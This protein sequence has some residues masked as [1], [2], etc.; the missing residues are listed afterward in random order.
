MRACVD[1]SYTDITEVYLQELRNGNKVNVQSLA[2]KFPQFAD[3]ILHELPL[4]AAL[5]T[6]LSDREAPLPSIP[7]YQLL[8]EI[9]RGN[10]GIVF[11]ARHTSGQLAAVKLVR[12]DR[13][14]ASIARLDREIESLSRL[15]HPNIVN[16]ESSGICDDYVY[17]AT[18]L[19]EG[20]T[21]AEILE[22]KPSLQARY[23]ASMLQ[24]DWNL[25]ATWG[26]Q[27]ASALEYIHEKKIIHRD[28]KPSNLLIDK[29]GKCWIIDFGLAKMNE[30]GM[31]LT[32]INRLLAPHASWPQNNCVESSTFVVTS[33]LSEERSTNWQASEAPMQRIPLHLL[34]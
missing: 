9:G 28:I 2:K 6:N 29:S 24:S 8:E 25:L 16:V 7:N 10:F 23:W 33:F 1:I 14:S 3:R 27:I 15:D 12:L 13:E 5:E 31:T 30:I 26:Q 17:I 21:L 11:K 22:A 34:L 20:I 4:M 19:V 32:Q 18:N